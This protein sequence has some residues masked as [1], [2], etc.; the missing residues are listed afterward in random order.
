MEADTRSRQHS[1]MSRR[2][3]KAQLGHL[4]TCLFNKFPKYVENWK[5]TYKP[6]GTDCRATMQYVQAHPRTSNSHQQGCIKWL[7]RSRT[8][9]IAYARD[10]DAINNK[11][12]RC[13]NWGALEPSW[14]ALVERAR[15]PAC[16]DGEQ[17]LGPLWATFGP[18][19]FSQPPQFKSTN[20]H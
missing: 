9:L 2:R 18:F 6:R 14:F 19:L 10:V 15:Q 11:I 1:M 3:P 17:L 7:C 12:C 13:L 16:A 4:T 5:L 20:Q 8:L